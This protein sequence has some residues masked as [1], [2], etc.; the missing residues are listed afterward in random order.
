MSKA[1][2]PD[3]SNLS[4]VKLALLE[5]RLGRVRA[6]S[7][8]EGTAA[9]ALA[10]AARAEETRVRASYSQENVW[11]LARAE[12]YFS[13][14]SFAVHLEGAFDARAL[15]R[16][17][18][19]LVR[20]HESLRTTFLS[21]GEE[22]FQTVRAHAEFHLLVSELTELPGAR[23]AEEVSTRLAELGREPYDPSRGELFRARLLKFSDGEHVLLFSILHLVC[24]R[25]SLGVLTRELSVLYNAFAE[26][27]PSPL[28]EPEM[29][30]PDYAATQRRD[31]GGAVFESHRAY[32]RRQLADCPVALS[33]PTSRMRPRVQT[34]RGGRERFA[35]PAE[36]AAGLRALCQEEGASLYMGT[37]S[38]LVALL[39]RYTG[40]SDIP[41]GTA[42]AG[43][44]TAAEESLIG[45]FL[46]PLL[47][48]VTFDGDPTFRELLRRVRAVTLEAFSH[49]DFPL[50]NLID[51]LRPHRDPSLPALAQ[52][53]H[54][55]HHLPP[56]R[57][58]GPSGVRMGLEVL[59][60][61]R[62]ALDLLLRVEDTR[63]ALGGILEYNAD[64]YESTVAA[65]LCAHYLNLLRDAI[66]DPERRLSKLALLGGAERLHLRDEACGERVAVPAGRV[67]E[68]FEASAA[69]APSRD[70]LSRGDVR[71]NY[72][73]LD[74]RACRVASLLRGAAVTRRT[75]V[76]VLSD[77]P[78]ERLVAALA[79]LKAGATYV[80]LDADAPPELQRQVLSKTGVAVLLTT[81]RLR[82]S[83]A[84]ESGRVV[85]I[86]DAPEAAER[87]ASAGDARRGAEAPDVE[88]QSPAESAYVDY[89]GR[90]RAV[91]IEHGGLSNFAAW[92]VRICGLTP[93]DR[94]ACDGSAP[95]CVREGQMWAA[96]SAGACVVEPPPA[97]GEEPAA[98]RAWLS[99]SG[100]TVCFVGAPLA[101]AL[102]R[103]E[104]PEQTAPRVL[105]TG[106]ERLPH[107][108]T[109]RFPFSIIACY[110]LSAYTAV[111]AFYILLTEVADG[112][113]C[114]DCPIDNTQI[115][116]LDR[117]GEP[118]PPGVVG[119]LYVGG[120]G[121]ARGHLSP[122]PTAEHFV[123]DPFSKEPGARLYRTG[124][125][126]RL[127]PGGGFEPLGRG[128]AFAHVRG[129]AVAL[130][131]VEDAL[132]SHPAVRRAAAVGL[133]RGEGVTL[134]AYVV[135]REGARVE[136]GE[137]REFLG[138]RLS[139]Y[140]LPDEIVLVERL[141]TTPDGR[142]DREALTRANS[143]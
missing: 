117:A 41:V 124:D 82:T 91:E 29:Q 105:L 128:P 101:A 60:T 59:D 51:E 130:A 2:R 83:D 77:E 122:A 102:M 118:V 39:H 99:Q 143:Q 92:H 90:G 138:R 110:T 37:L 74:E 64:L 106:G 93:A 68:L 31:N 100:V 65:G 114:T 111:A 13:A 35:F 97:L 123:P 120:A 103:E 25:W 115:Y 125:A 23:R 67:H 70:A 137:L 107:A 129:F 116:V 4:P 45:S 132:A 36:V 85:Y 78:A 10:P 121:L 24:D 3:A 98:W 71:L 127:L 16:A 56:P 47:L 11:A 21:E 140:M 63:T 38:A 1:E 72:G 7:S 89:G 49:Q 135:T 84:V 26:G 58:A 19:E 61:G 87:E 113:L 43:R 126:A 15:E 136:A 30:Y 48:R 96:L 17:L 55:L 142:A 20:R 28:P 46:N 62:T 22:L 12:G 33:L 81:R 108:P 8:G 42:V 141:P 131:Q 18:G 86:E 27:R 94:V 54:M 88:P 57:E 73:E 134:A 76:G 9:A 53:G 133:G 69:S 52:V 109:A 5:K 66:S 139:R 34:F 44:R 6:A 50:Q 119:E 75:R 40:G 80:P 104:W 95:R 112:S 79:A 14:Y 32:W